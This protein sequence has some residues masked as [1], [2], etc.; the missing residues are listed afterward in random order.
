MLDSLLLSMGDNF[1][2]GKE[3]TSVITSAVQIDKLL[4]PS[5]GL[6]PSSLLSLHISGQC[7]PCHA[8]SNG[9]LIACIILFDTV[10]HM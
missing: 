5:V 2:V 6:Q 3:L 1:S 4:R 9:V 10:L 7:T 8:F